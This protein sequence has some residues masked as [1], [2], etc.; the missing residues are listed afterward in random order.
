MPHGPLA[1]LDADV[2][3]SF[4]LRNL[5]LHLAVAERFEPLWSEEILAECLRALGE[6]ADL[7]LSQRSH[8]LERMH[9]SFPGA[10]GGGFARA[11]DGLPLPDDA[12]R[13]V[14][15]LAL[16]Y[17]AEFIVTRN[18]R[19][20]PAHLLHPLGTE[21]IDPDGF[22]EILFVIDPESVVAAAEV[23]RCSLKRRPLDPA[24]YLESLRTHAGVP[25]TA[26]LLQSAGFL[27][28]AVRRP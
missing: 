16:H 15:A 4:Q 20:F 11:A 12:E 22:V 28:P 26:D 8:L 10:L 9:A 23:H 19:H 6:H 1:V 13:L 17:E 18:L 25:R 5:L 3:F 2:L 14:I 24:A 21:P 27:E 7:T